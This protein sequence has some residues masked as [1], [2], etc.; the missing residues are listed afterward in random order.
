MI[1]LAPPAGDWKK[2]DA[3]IRDYVWNGKRPQ[4]KWSSLQVSKSDGGMACPNF[5]LYHRAFVLRN[6]KFWMDENTV[7]S[8]KNIEQEPIVTIRLKYFLFTG[9]S[10]K[11]CYLY[12]GPILT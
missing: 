5:K 9:L 2:I 1:T 3:V 12:Y 7:S 10:T 8:M 11:K 4:L 6:L